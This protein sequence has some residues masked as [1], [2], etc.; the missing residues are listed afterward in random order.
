[1]DTKLLARYLEFRPAWP[2]FAVYIF[3]AAIFLLGPMINPQ[4]PIRPAL[5]QLLGTCFVAFILLK[6]FTSLYRI[7][8][9]K[10]LAETSFPSRRS[11]QASIAEITRIDL[12]RGIT[13][14]LMGV[15]HVHLYTGE[16]SEPAVKLFGVPRPDEFRRLLLDMG[17]SDRPVTGAWR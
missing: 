5:S 12:R 16:G 4:A 6:R 14:R 2:S 3:G 1:M 9:G 13:Q 11:Q 17:A 10:I 8:G 15:A 7:E